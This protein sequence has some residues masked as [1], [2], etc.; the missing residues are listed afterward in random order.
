MQP[1]DFA[2][3]WDPHRSDNRANEGDF[4]DAFGQTF[5]QVLDV[6]T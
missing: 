2:A 4:E 1:T 6:D 3:V 5:E